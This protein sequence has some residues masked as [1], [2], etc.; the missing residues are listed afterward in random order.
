[1]E[2]DETE[3]RSLLLANDPQFQRLA[4]QH[5]RFDE[6]LEELSS[7]RPFTEEDRYREISLKKQ[8]LLVKDRMA[9][10]VRRHMQQERTAASA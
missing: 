5:D 6:M 7:K 1:M 2:R 8:K 10:M 3:V 4:E 9:A